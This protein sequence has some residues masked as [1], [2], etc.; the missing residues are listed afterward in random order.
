VSGGDHLVDVLRVYQGSN[1]EATLA[2]YKRLERLGAA[3]IVA[4]NLF[5]A[6]KASERAKVYRG[7]G[8]RGA[9]YDKKQWSMNNAA[10]ALTEHAGQL[11]I[12]WGWGHDPK[13]PRHNWVLYVDLPAG[14]EGRPSSAGGEGRPSSAGGQV[15]FHTETRGPGPDYPGAWDGMPG[16]SAERICRWVARLLAQEPA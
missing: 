5:R 2:L 3:G 9:A 14:G 16:H 12:V 13:Q 15:S 1:G 7:S 11:G 6:G 10:A 4:V 8:Y